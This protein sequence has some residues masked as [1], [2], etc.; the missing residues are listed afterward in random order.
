MPALTLHDAH[1]IAR[2]MAVSR[3]AFASF[4][5]PSLGFHHDV[6]MQCRNGHTCV[7]IRD[8]IRHDSSSFI[9]IYIY[10]YI[11]LAVFRSG[12]S[13]VCQTIHEPITDRVTVV[14]R[15]VLVIVCHYTS[16]NTYGGHH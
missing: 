15:H 16:T 12:D 9:Y 14:L 2:V 13:Y 6:D 10:I 4:K 5:R 7:A 3:F 1:V 11:S 8:R